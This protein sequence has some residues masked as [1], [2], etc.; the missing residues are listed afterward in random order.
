MRKFASK[1]GADKTFGLQDKDG[2]CCIENKET[3]IKENNIIVGGK[4]YFGTSGLWDLIVET[5][6]DDKIFTDGDFD[7][8]TEIMHSTNAL[9][10]NNDKS[11]T[12]PKINRGLKW[13]QILK[14][15]WNEKDIYTENGI[16]LRFSPSFYHVTLLRL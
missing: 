7:N 11:E 16:P 10:L 2:K 4:E 14:Q 6:P 13:K 12:K 1:S 9:R 15:V 5:A 3:K 8:N